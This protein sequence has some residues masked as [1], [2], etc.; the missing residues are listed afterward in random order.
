MCW[1]APVSLSTFLFSTIPLVLCLYFQ[2]IDIQKY[3]VYQTFFSM[4]LLEY[5]LWTF[6]NN[7]LG[8]LIFSILGFIFIF[9]L[10]F[11][12]IYASQN[13]YTNYV[14]G[15]YIL[16]AIYVLYTI[17]IKFHT[18]IAPNKHLNWEWLNLPLPVVILWS[19]FFMYSS[20]YSIYSGNYKDMMMILFTLFIYLFSFY[21]YY[22]SNTFG[23]MWCWIANAHA[24]YFYYLFI[25][26]VGMSMLV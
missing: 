18:S 25:K 21:Y 16:F 4:Q 24:I 22:S 1:S 26:Y 20:M 7:K 3:L 8:N 13:K 6:L 9:L 15:L 14:L 19:F 2:L 11:F 17:P 23:T 10:S 12:S 5:F